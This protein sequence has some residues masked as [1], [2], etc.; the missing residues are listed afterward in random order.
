VQHSAQGKCRGCQSQNKSLNPNVKP[1]LHNVIFTSKQL[2]LLLF[3]ETEVKYGYKISNLTF[4]SPKKIIHKCDVCGLPKETPYKV[5]MKEKSLS[6]PKC[7]TVKT[8]QTNLVKYGVSNA[9]NIDIPRRIEKFKQNIKQTVKKRRQTSLKK[10][11][12]DH[13]GKSTEVQEKRK[14][15]CIERYGVE[16]PWQSIEVRDKMRQTML[17]K[18]GVGSPLQSAEVMQKMQQTNMDRYGVEFTTQSEEVKEKAKQTNI[19]KYGVEHPWQSKEIREKIRQTFIEKYGVDN[20]TQSILIQEKVRQTNMERIGVEYPIQLP[21]YR[22][23]IKEWCIDNPEKLFTSKSELEV[24]E[25]VRQYYPESKKY[26][27]G[28]HEIDVFIPNINLG[29]EFD[30]LY[31]HQEDRVGQKYHINKTKYFKDKGIRIIHIFE[32]EWR[33]RKNQVKS[34]LLSAIGKNEIRIGARKCQVLWSSESQD[35]VVVNKFLETYHIQ[36]ALNRNTEYVVKVIFNNNLL[37]VATFGKHHRNNTDWVLTRFCTKANFTIQGVLSKISKLASQQLRTDILSWA[38]YRLSTGNGYE[39]AG[40][41]FEQLL[42]PDYFYHKSGKVFSKQSRQ[43]KT[44][45]T[46][47][48]ITERQHAKIDGLNRVFDCGKIRYRYLFNKQ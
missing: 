46:P 6:H 20:P 13:P 17:E 25:W 4:G 27:D 18:Y 47:E 42:P 40:W 38:D 34:F 33:D 36:G 16:H 41:V 35:I 2:S 45:N 31:Y 7:K 12:V 10:Y 1:I 37:A 11:G 44:V 22:N 14:Q 23:M 26:K 48:G 39:K 29:I 15:T 9:C 8:Q 19:E 5:F 3:Q 21:Q 30:G 24:L 28:T 32:H 43:K